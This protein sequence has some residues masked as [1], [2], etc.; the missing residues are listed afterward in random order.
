MVARHALL[1]SFSIVVFALH[2]W[3][4]S[5]VINTFNL[6]W[7]ELG[8]IAATASLMDSSALNSFDKDLIINFQFQNL[9]NLHAA[10]SKHLVQLFSLDL[11]AREAVE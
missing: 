9:I 11:S 1:K 7:I 3:F 5:D 4:S 6:W 10:S 8:V 2:Q